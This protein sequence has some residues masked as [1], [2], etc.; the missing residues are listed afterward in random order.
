MTALDQV[1]LQPHWTCSL[2]DLLL[3]GPSPMLET[4]R[5]P[6]PCGLHPAMSVHRKPHTFPRG[7]T[8][9]SVS[10][11][12]W[13]GVDASAVV[14]E[15]GG[16]RKRWQL[17]SEEGPSKRDSLLLAPAGSKV[18]RRSEHRHN[19]E[20]AVQTRLMSEPSLHHEPLLRFR[21]ALLWALHS[22]RNCLPR[23]V[24]ALTTARTERDALALVRAGR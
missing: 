7:L 5:F 22:G 17:L 6:D 21:V 23:S 14:L 19:T 8:W 10:R 24:A 20:H 2:S 13:W 18:C 3:V 9:T 1:V 4:P 11:F 15:K 16:M 12:A